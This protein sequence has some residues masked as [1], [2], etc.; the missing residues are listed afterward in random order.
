[1]MPAA[2]SEIGRTTCASVNPYPLLLQLYT[3][4]VCIKRQS[5]AGFAV[6]PTP[7]GHDFCYISSYLGL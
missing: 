4:C 3:F 1:M 5:Q 6:E 2:S 7:S